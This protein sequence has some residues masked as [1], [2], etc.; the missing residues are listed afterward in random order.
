MY[1]YR[2]L[3][4]YHDIAVMLTR[5]D[6]QGQ[7]QGLHSVCAQ[8]LNKYLKF[9]YTVKIISC[10]KDNFHIDIKKVKFI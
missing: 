10:Q 9:S 5:L 7:D 1:S 4:T 2:S 6:R 8:G 3:S